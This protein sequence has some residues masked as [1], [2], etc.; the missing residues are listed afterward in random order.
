MKKQLIAGTAALAMASPAAVLADS[1]PDVYGFINLSVDYEGGYDGATVTDDNDNEA[2]FED[3]D[4]TMSSS[5][6][7]VGVRGE[8]G[9]D[10]GLTALYQVELGLAMAGDSSTRS[11]DQ[12]FQTRDTFVGLEGDFGTVRLGRMAFGNQWAYD[13]A[14]VFFV[15]QM[16]GPQDFAFAGQGTRLDRTVRYDAPIP[17]P[18]GVTASTA[19]QG[20]AGDENDD[21]AYN[22]RLT[23]AEGPLSG[24]ATFWHLDGD[25]DLSIFSLGGRYDLGV[26][27]IGAQVV[28]LSDDEDDS[29]H[30]TYGLGAK[31]PIG[32][33]MAVKAAVS[34]WDDDRSDW[35]S[36]TVGLGLDYYFS[37]RTTLYVNVASTSNDDNSNRNP[38][39]VDSYGPTSM[40]EV[41]S[42]DAGFD[43]DV[44]D[45]TAQAERLAVDETHTGV[46]IGIAHSF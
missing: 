29:D 1:G 34:Q 19:L 5:L 38:A 41:K 45:D 15:G 22:L 9:L 46:Q 2:T 6:S 33:S 8:E 21:H 40:N 23:Y 43:E 37:D 17:G 14:G 30:T 11:G 12:W 18:F 44:I 16:G 35:D 25:D 4:L 39:G 3:G 32:P 31:M 24:A 36:T 26:A 27:E 10:G 28:S 7:Q 13:G 42:Q 20:G